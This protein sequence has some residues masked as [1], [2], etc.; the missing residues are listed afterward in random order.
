MKKVTDE[1]LVRL[2]QDGDVLAYEELVKRYQHGLYVFLLRFVHDDT[3]ASDIVQ[4]SLVKV[5]E[6]IDRID[7][8]KKFSTFVFEIAKNFAISELRRRNK[9]V[10]L[11][12]IVD[13]TE[14]K[15]FI[16]ELYRSDVG[17]I[18]RESVRSLPEK[19]RTVITL[20]Y[21]D[22]LSYEEIAGKL[23]IPVNTVRTHLKR[24]K[25]QLKKLLEPYENN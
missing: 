14:E 12:E 19:Y 10:S 5:Y 9:T 22:D 4:N 3:I 17:E 2:I 1:E 25:E 11:E 6:V 23:H 20:Y 18:V 24:A 13:I 8:S 21:F 16:E 7:T 15:S